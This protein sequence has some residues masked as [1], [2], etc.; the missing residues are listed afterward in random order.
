MDNNNQIV[1]QKFLMRYQPLFNWSLLVLIIAG[2][3]MYILSAT[4]FL[5]GF[6]GFFHIKYSQILGKEFFIDKLPWLQETIHKASFRDHHMLWHYLLVPFAFGDLIQGGQRA[7]L[8]SVIFLGLGLYTVLLKSEIKFPL[9]WTVTALLSSYPFLFRMSMLRV[10]SVSLTFLLI[11]F[12]FYQQK[13]Y[14]GIYILTILYVWL[15][16]GFP[17]FLV[18]SILFAISGRVFEKTWD[19]KIIWY[20]LGGIITGMI[21]NPYFPENISSLLYNASRSIFLNVEGIKLGNEWSPYSSW[22][23]V[24]NS[25]PAFILLVASIITL[26]LKKKIT[27]HQFS[28]LLVNILFL[29]LTFKSRRFI[30]YWPVF[31]VLSAALLLGKELSKKAIIIGF[32]LLA[33]LLVNNLN[34]ARGDVANTQSPLTYEGAAKWLKAN[35]KPGEIVFNA[36]WDDFP[37]LFFYNS[38]NYYIVG[39]D[40]MYLY[41][42]DNIKYRLYQKIT[43]GKLKNPA[44][45][46]KDK[47]HARYVF[48]DSHHKSLYRKLKKDDLTR[49]VYQGISSSVFEIR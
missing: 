27:T 41:T 7:V 34:K 47:F 40:P 46:I 4:T 49:Q 6:D 36:D 43:R 13:R 26:A 22:A 25:V 1:I 8:V 18:F 28:A 14:M 19:L 29:V 38:R 31:S 20:C 12:L 21:V 33:P 10:Q 37:F 39:L 15:Y 48:L 30:E 17:M 24:K 45:V 35:S 5:V 11:L 16:D 3:F 44:R 9:L 23:L 42:Y 32:L 2:I